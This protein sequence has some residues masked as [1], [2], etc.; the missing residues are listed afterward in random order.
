MQWSVT[1]ASR[2]QVCWVCI[3]GRP[4]AY[5]E[6]TGA[7]LPARSGRCCFVGAVHCSR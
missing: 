5:A 4:S 6:G 1:S 2:M 3:S 7:K